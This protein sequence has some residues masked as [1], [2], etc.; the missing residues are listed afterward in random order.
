MLHM[1][2]KHGG[3]QLF[4]EGVAQL[5]QLVRAACVHCDTIRSRRCHRCSYRKRD[6]PTRNLRV[7]DT[8][9]DRRQ[10]GHQDAAPE[11]SPAI[12]QPLHRSQ[13]VP[14]GHFLGGSP[15]PNCPIL[16]LR[17]GTGS[18]LPSCAGPPRWHSC[19][20]WSLATPRLGRRVSKEP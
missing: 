5:R 14:P 13:P 3:Q 4:H 1:I 17:C 9:Q 7:G 12:H 15:L 18:Y 20:A 16:V 2:Q 19:D 6:T 10:P 8:F 11:G